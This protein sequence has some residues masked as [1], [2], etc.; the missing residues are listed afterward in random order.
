MSVLSLLM[1]SKF[2]EVGFGFRL[3]W[4]AEALKSPSIFC[5]F[6]APKKPFRSVLARESDFL[7]ARDPAPRIRFMTTQGTIFALITV[8]MNSL[9]TNMRHNEE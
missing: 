2:L 9:I 8:V 1:L 5:S 7:E 6:S 3:I 4:L